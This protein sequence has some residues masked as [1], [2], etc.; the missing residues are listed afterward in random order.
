MDDLPLSVPRVCMLFEDVDGCQ[1]NRE[2]HM[3]EA[4]SVG[5]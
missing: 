2:K 5:I 4:P 1:G 3:Y